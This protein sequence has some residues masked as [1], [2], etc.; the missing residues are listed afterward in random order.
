MFNDHL[1]DE[2]LKISEGWQVYT[3]QQFLCVESA[4][5]LP[6]VFTDKLALE[7]LS[8]FETRA[9]DTNSI[10]FGILRAAIER[11]PNSRILHSDRAIS[12]FTKVGVP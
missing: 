6:L 9:T 1:W 12:T 8:F 10:V 7:D 2:H 11:L 5:V 3:S 4:P